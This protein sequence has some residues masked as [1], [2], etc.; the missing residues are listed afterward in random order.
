MGSN[1][2]R[3]ERKK[4]NRLQP[5]GKPRK[6]VARPQDDKPPLSMSEQIRAGVPPRPKR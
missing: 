5:G 6:P 2:S 1:A 4:A 3:R